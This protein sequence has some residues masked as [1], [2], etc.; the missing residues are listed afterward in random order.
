MEMGWT[1]PTNFTTRKPRSEHEL[2][3][4]VFIDQETFA[5]KAR[6]GDFAE[7]TNYRRNLYAMT[8][9]LDRT[10][11]N[12]IVVDPIGK[13]A[14]EAFLIKSKVKFFRVWVECPEQV[15]ERRLE[16]RRTSVTEFNERMSDSEWFS[17]VNGTYDLT[18]DGTWPSQ[19]AAKFIIKYADSIRS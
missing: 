7:W 13:G 16:A 9:Y 2:D 18:V 12:V 15:R 4:Y 11:D 10:K 8:K 5:K 1:R 19:E 14:F 3:E 6:N 17:R